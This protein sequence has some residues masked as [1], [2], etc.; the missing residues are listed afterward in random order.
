MTYGSDVPALKGP[1]GTLIR[2][3]PSLLASRRKAIRALDPFQDAPV[4]IDRFRSHRP[5]FFTF[6]TRGV[7]YVF[8]LGPEHST[9][10]DITRS[11]GR[12]AQ[13]RRL[14]Y[15]QSSKR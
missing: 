14:L 8:G 2:A 4:W 11:C 10:S 6:Q 5:L 3:D 9:S 7:L 1:T 15:Y 12:K 13:R